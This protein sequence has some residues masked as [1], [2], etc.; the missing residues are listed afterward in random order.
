MK[1][2]PLHDDTVYLNVYEK[3][4]N[5]RVIF[6]GGWVYD[7]YDSIYDS[8][9][10]EHLD[11]ILV[12]TIG[13]VT[14]EVRLKKYDSYEAYVTAPN[15]YVNHYQSIGHTVDDLGYAN[16][17]TNY[18]YNE[19][20]LPGQETYFLNMKPGYYVMDFR[21]VNSGTAMDVY[22]SKNFTATGSFEVLAENAG[23]NHSYTVDSIDDPYVHAMVCYCGDSYEVAHTFLEKNT[24]DKQWEDAYG[25]NLEVRYCTVAGC[26]EGNYRW[27][28]LESF[29]IDNAD[30]QEG[31]TDAYEK[32][33]AVEQTFNV[34]AKLD[35]LEELSSSLNQNQI[36]QYSKELSKLLPVN[37]KVNWTTSNA[38][39]ATVDAN[40][41]VT[42]VGEGT[43]LITATTVQPGKETGEPMT[44]TILISVNCQHAK[45]MVKVPAKA[46][47]CQADGHVEHYMCLDCTK[48]SLTGDFTDTVSYENDIK[49][50]KVD[51]AKL[52]GVWHADANGHWRECKYECGTRYDEQYHYS[53]ED[54]NCQHP[55]YCAVCDYVLAPVTDHSHYTYGWSDGYHW[56]ICECGV[57][58]EGS[59]EVHQFGA[60]GSSDTCDDCGYKKNVGYT[61]SGTITSYLKGEGDITVQLIAADETVAYST[62]VNTYSGTSAFTS[63]FSIPEV[64]DGT[65]TLRVSKAN[66]VT[67][68][69][70][71][72]VNAAD[73]TQDV[74]IHL[75]GD[76][77]GDGKINSLDKKKVYNH[78]NGDALTG[79][80]FDVA[81]VRSTDTKIN[82]LDKKMIYN[83][84][85]GES[86]WE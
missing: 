64:V 23:H 68:D 71:V 63:T 5:V 62:V 32:T 34:V 69:Y 20:K 10:S 83:H 52:Y 33:M 80:E 74:K 45:H 14:V 67:R 66:H 13:G 17:T 26:G 18:Q 27:R 58:V 56:S 11:K 7:I 1:F 82:S 78:I 85:N 51:H 43:A 53:Y 41:I 36:Q 61:V 39:V 81:N 15:T 42:A 46:P 3:G 31:K 25:S 4:S 8:N 38:D 28:F 47:T 12:P 50:A 72:T 59:N 57:V 24:T 73:F 35:F 30:L 79:Y 21:V 49:L 6:D 9:R 16:V 76:V 22:G 2:Q 29:T 65:Y 60:D 86:L 77:T 19:N 40:G 48:Y 84:I 54:A 37:T 55:E 70:T 75:L 44:A